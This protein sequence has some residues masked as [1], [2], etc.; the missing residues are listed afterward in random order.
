MIELDRLT[1]SYGDVVAVDRLSLSVGDGEFVALLGPSGCGKSTVL[2]MLAGLLEPSGGRVLLDGDDIT[3]Q[4]PKDRDL[5]MVFQSYALY[6]HLDVRSNLEFGLKAH[7]TE[8][9]VIAARV[10]EV[11]GQLGLTELLRRRPKELSGGQR[12]RVAVGRAI[13]RRPRA[14]LMDEPLSNLDARLRTATRREL[15]ALHRQLGATIVYVTHDQVE[16]MTMATKIVVMNGGRIEQVGSPLEVYDQPA[17]TFVAGFLGAPP[18]NLLHG[19]VRSRNGMVVIEA[20][21][22]HVAIAEGSTEERPITIGVRPEEI[23]V[24]GAI[25]P[26]DE[27]FADGIVSLV[28]NLGG[29]EISYIEAG[30]QTI[31]VRSPRGAGPAEGDHPHLAVDPR[32][33]HLFDPESGRRL[34]WSNA[35]SP[36][37]TPAASFRP[38][39][40]VMS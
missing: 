14:F 33:V 16:A 11:A 22:I 6:P 2:R 30:E 10:D 35:S 38:T 36:A 40:R 12:Q 15:V 4:P 23:R 21:G 18:M 31:A 9:P 20:P 5:A 19:T 1:K 3:Y 7:H 39:T 26:G 24:A 34:R 8:A 13:A 32:R 37:T 25:R 28:E 29:E 17:S 27:P